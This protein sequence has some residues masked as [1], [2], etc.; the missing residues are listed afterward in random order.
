M[1]VK[2][3]DV[4]LVIEKMDRSDGVIIAAPTYMFSTPALVKNLIDRLSYLGHRP[5]Y[6][7][8]TCSN[9]LYYLRTRTQ[10]AA[11]SV[12]LFWY[13]Q[14]LGI[15]TFWKT[16]R[17][18]HPFFNGEKSRKKLD[19]TIENSCEEISLRLANTESPHISFA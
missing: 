19:N 3:D 17:F 5:R 16:W 18:T 14:C 7:G 4:K 6:T 10:G 9:D 1:P 13:S 12:S 2:K 15:Q 8:K 11:A